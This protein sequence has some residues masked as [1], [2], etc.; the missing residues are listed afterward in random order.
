M[1]RLYRWLSFGLIILMLAQAIPIAN[2]STLDCEA[3]L[4][5]EAKAKNDVKIALA[6][7]GLAISN[8]IVSVGG[9]LGLLRLPGHKKISFDK[10][11]TSGCSDFN[12][13]QQAV[14]EYDNAYIT[15]HAGNLFLTQDESNALTV[16]IKSDGRVMFSAT[17]HP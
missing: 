10:T 6:A 16:E 15:V 2:A 17:I 5:H 14:S 11:Y 1:N 8:R 13:H 9:G 12:R 4:Y 3:Y 7:N